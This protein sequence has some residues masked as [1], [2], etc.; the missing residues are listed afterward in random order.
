MEIK[1]EKK[2]AR[3]ID[4]Y[5]HTFIVYAHR[6]RNDKRKETLFRYINKENDEEDSG[7]VGDVKRTDN[8]V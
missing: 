1:N 7:D 4:T 2:D 8:Q 3:K 5:K 6:N